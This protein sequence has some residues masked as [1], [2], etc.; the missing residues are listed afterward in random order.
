M[1]DRPPMHVELKEI[2]IGKYEDGRLRLEFDQHIAMI[3][4]GALAATGN[5]I[6]E[7]PAGAIEVTKHLVALIPD[8]TVVQICKTLVRAIAEVYTEGSDD[9]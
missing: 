1:S 7:D 4:A 6:R 3:V 8:N 2:V 9:E 5:L